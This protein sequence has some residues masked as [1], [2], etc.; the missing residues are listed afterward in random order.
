MP[1]LQN[2]AKEAYTGIG[3]RE[4]IETVTWQRVWPRHVDPLAQSF[5]LTEDRFITAVGL[6]FKTKDAAKPVTVQIRNMVNGY[7]G[8]T[9]L[10]SKTLTPAEVGVSDTGA[11]ETKV[12]FDEPVLLYR[13]TEYCIV[14]ISD[15]DTYCIYIA[16]MAGTDLISGSRVT[17][18][19]YTVGVL[20]SSSN[21]TTWSAH[22]DADLKFKLYGAVFSDQAVLQFQNVAVTNV[23]QLILAVGELI[24][25][26]CGLSWQWS[27]DGAL[28][29][30]LA[31]GD[32]TELT[33]LQTTV[34]VRALLTKGF[35]TSPV[36]HANTALLVGMSYKAAGVY[37]T[38]QVTAEEFTE[39]LVYLD[40]NTPSGTAQALQYSIDDGANWVDFGAPTSKQV[41][42]NFYQY[43]Y[44]DTLLVGATTIRLRLN[45]SST[46]GLI[47][48]RAKRL[49]LILS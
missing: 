22:Q 19:P 31:D 11:T 29:F 42:A 25:E 5:T 1:T 46:S 43:R 15:A 38:K 8:A 20:F 24:P 2:E 41:D 44:T 6:Y 13:D 30:A 40:L 26:G 3:R 47:T 36:I 34:Y 14:V 48:P 4:I 10:V 49:M 37:V 18:Q 28:W 16:K 21:A 33:A 17:K 45:T 9:V 39:I 27:N 32:A 23:G 35:K 12:T 7:P